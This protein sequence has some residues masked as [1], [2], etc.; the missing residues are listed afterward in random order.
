MED[1]GHGLL[2]PRPVFVCQKRVECLM[3]KEFILKSQ[4][5]REY[6]PE[7]D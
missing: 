2:V 6:E 1:P 3:K 7:L 4:H 5:G